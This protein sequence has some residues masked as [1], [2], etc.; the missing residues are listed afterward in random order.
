MQWL[1]TGLLI[2]A[3]AG[4]AAFT[5]YLLRRLFTTLPGTPDSPEE[6]AG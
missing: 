2:A 1:F 4:I 6:A 5:G 3:S